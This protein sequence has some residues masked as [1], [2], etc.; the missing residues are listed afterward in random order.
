MDPRIESN[1]GV[2]INLG[3]DSLVIVFSEPVY[4]I[5]N[6][7]GML[8]AADFEVLET[9]GGAAPTV[10]NVLTA[11]NQTVTVLLSR[12]ITPLEWTTVIAHV[13]DCDG[14]FI[15]SE[16]DLGEID[17]PDRVDISFLP[18]DINMDGRTLPI[19]LL[20]FQQFPNGL[21]VPP[22]GEQLDI[23]DTD[24]DGVLDPSDVEDPD[25][26]LHAFRDL[27]NGTGPATQS[28][29]VELNSERP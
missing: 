25:S 12:I 1:N 11:D 29:A 24:R 28:W 3:V 27:V 21:Y 20:R 15:E 17:E 22:Q 7:G 19:D 8:T 23:F 13:Q 16:G 6:A 2:D 9:G 18:G 14:K 26:D 4:P 5:G 10:D